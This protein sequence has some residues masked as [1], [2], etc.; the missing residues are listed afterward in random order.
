VAR[1]RH[2][3]LAAL[4]LVLVQAGVGM[5]V[6]LYVTVPAHHR[7]ARPA[8]YLTGSLHSVTWAIAHGVLALAIHAA[9]GLALA[10]LVIGVAARTFVI[11]RWP[12]RAWSV[13]A[14]LFVV[15]AGFNGASFLDFGNNVSSLVMALLAFGAVACY[16]VV[17]YLLGQAV[18]PAR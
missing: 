2:S 12:V 18:S 1:L 8:N 4:V 15:G 7:G 17:L 16:A 10:V 14:A 11:A 6:N 3:A 9:L 5:A 13:L